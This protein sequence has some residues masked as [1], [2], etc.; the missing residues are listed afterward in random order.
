MRS[1]LKR[2]KDKKEQSVE[3]SL[4]G[5][6][7]DEDDDFH[8][9]SDVSGAASFVTPVSYMRSCPGLA[10]ISGFIRLKNA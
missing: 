10:K 1:F 9:T 6:S 5:E 7:A 8:D 4:K 2:K 3:G